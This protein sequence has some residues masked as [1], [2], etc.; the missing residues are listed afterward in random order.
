MVYLII[1]AIPVLSIFWWVWA[2]RRLNRLGASR[3]WTWIVAVPMVVLL[4][5]FGWILLDRGGKVPMRLPSPVYAGVML[6]GLVFLPLLALPSMFGWGAWA[7]LARIVRFW[8]RSAAGET[9]AA[10]A[11]EVGGDELG[12]PLLLTRRQ[13]LATAAVAMPVVATLGVTGISIPQVTRFRIRDLSL[14][15]P[16]LPSDLDGL[17]IAHLTDTHVGK[18]TNGRVL[19]ELAEA[20]N[21]L[22][23]DLVLLTGDL[24]DT[25]LDDLPAAM[26]MVN[27]MDP[28]SGLVLIEGNHDLFG[29]AEN[30]ARGVRSYGA[31]LLRD[32]A[33]TLVVRGQPLQILGVRWH[34]RSGEIERHVDAVAALRD[35]DAFPILLAHHPHAFDRAAELGFPLTLAGHTHG[36]QIMLTPEFGA[37]S[38][39]FK[40]LSGHYQ[41]GASSLVVSNG[42]GNW[43]PLRTHA[44]AEII[45]LTLRRA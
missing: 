10:P 5:G 41:R 14:V 15:I 36:G 2:Q 4:A 42:A 31:T 45:H 25:S 8:R 26:G 7:A 33:T 30:F 39:I 22:K 19:N 13:L 34:G 27:S 16:G 6:W 35:P 44:P 1:T 23:A 11:A 40:Y 38:M 32:E 9:L 18:F 29:G 12:N 43:F 17:R 24:L 21:R 37:G 20:T 28:R 3:K